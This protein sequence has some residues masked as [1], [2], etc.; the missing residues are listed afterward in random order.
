MSKKDGH[1]TIPPAKTDMGI[2]VALDLGG[3]EV[4]A[5]AAKK[6]DQ[7][8]FEFVSSA[9][10]PSRG[11]RRGAIYNIE[12]TKNDIKHVLT[13]L[14]NSIKTQYNKNIVDVYDKIN[15][16]IEQVYIALNGNSRSE[17]NNM[18]RRMG[19]NIIDKELFDEFDRENRNFKLNNDL[20][21]LDIYPF[22]FLVDDDEPTNNP[23]G[24]RCEVISATYKIIVGKN[25]LLSNLRVCLESIG[26]KLAGYCVAPLAAANAVLSNNE[27]E[28]GVV[29]IDFGATS[30]NV[31]IYH[32]NKLHYSLSIPIGSK[33]ITD[34]IARLRIVAEEAEKIKKIGNCHLDRNEKDILIGL[35]TGNDISYKVI[36]EVIERRIDTIL[37]Y[38]DLAI[39]ESKLAV[40]PQLDQ[41]VIVGEAAN[42][43][44]LMGK[45]EETLGLPAH[46][47]SIHSNYQHLIPQSA[48]GRKFHVAIGTLVIAKENC[49]VSTKQ[50]ERPQAKTSFMGSVKNAITSLFDE[51]LPEEKNQ[52]KRQQ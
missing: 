52:K 24:C 41:A 6:D 28:L 44:G 36:C 45:I 3:T 13:D 25:T 43:K 26:V 39:K 46:K 34:D 1:V 27:K 7:G 9:S 14:E 30:T 23:I 12:D 37:A 32:K 47:G 42:L 16:K 40:G 31:A 2:F 11:I 38:V 22:K 29:L 49:V 21:I 35:S 51:E 17:T 5:I 8:K 20:E 50:A 10:T 18:S 33:V 48:N 19:G 15:V 4:R